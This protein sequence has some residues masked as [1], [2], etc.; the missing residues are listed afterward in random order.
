MDTELEYILRQFGKDCYWYGEDTGDY[1]CD[2]VAKQDWF[3]EYVE[4]I[5]QLFTH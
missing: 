1:D 2:F 5:K 4:Q 3:K